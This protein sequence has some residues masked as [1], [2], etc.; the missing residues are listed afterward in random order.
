MRLGKQMQFF[1]A[2]VNLAEREP[3]R[4]PRKMAFMLLDLSRRE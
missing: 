1:G 3:R 2:R 4:R